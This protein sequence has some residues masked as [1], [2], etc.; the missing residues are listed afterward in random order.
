MFVEID[1]PLFATTRQDAWADAKLLVVLWV[2]LRRMV[3]LLMAVMFRHLV[4]LM[5][6]R[7]VNVLVTVRV[8]GVILTLRMVVRLVGM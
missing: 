4:L 1:C 5:L 7:Q 8:M 6:L 3:V 2:L